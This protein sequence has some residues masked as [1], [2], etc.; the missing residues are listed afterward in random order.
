MSD[1]IIKVPYESVQTDFVNMDDYMVRWS[2]NLNKFQQDSLQKIQNDLWTQY[3]EKEKQL[4][5][6]HI[7]ADN[8][9]EIEIMK[10]YKIQA[11]ENN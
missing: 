9:K 2:S 6:E 5:I 10:I 8:L 7:K 11:S 4:R 1:T 3:N